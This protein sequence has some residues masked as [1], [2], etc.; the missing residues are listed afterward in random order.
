[1]FALARLRPGA[2]LA[3]AEAE[4]T[5]AAR[6]TVRPMAANLL[7]GIGGPPVVHVRGMVDEMTARVRPALLV[8]AGAVVCVLLIACANVANLFL[9]RGVARQR[10]LT[11]RAAIGASRG[12]LA[13]QLLTES[14]V[15]CVIGGALGLALAW[16]L[17]R[18]APAVV[19]RRFPAARCRPPRDAAIVFTAA[20]ALV[21]AIISGLVPALRGARF[22]LAES[23]HGGDGASAGGFRG[24]RARRLREGLLVAESAFAVLLLV[25]ATL[26]A[27]SFVKL[28]Q[29]D[30]GYTSTGVLASASTCR[31]R[32]GRAAARMNT[33]WPRSSSARARRRASSRPAP[34][35]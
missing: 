10:E 34:A 3:Q 24:L 5:A 23:L 20:A 4:G 14:A 21:T 7:F 35:T 2:T 27:R 15:L 13:R 26:L 18:I 28:T 9:S 6:T 22:N 19:S 29:V 11:V 25:A 1:M 30:A 33:P 31:R 8:L 12:R 32:R 16:A 17:V